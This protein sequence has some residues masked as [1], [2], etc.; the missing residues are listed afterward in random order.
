MDETRDKSKDANYFLDYAKRFFVTLKI[1]M[2]QEKE[3]ALGFVD[4]LDP[5]IDLLTDSLKES[6]YSYSIETILLLGSS[7]GEAFR[8]IFNGQWSFSEKQGRWII[9]IQ[10]KDGSSME[11][12]VFRKIENRIINGMEDSI[13]YY[14]QSTK[15]LL[16]KGFPN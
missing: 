7:L 5:T 11:M 8:L 14:Y 10:T 3:S 15:S 4:S 13:L 1:P 6:G 9:A 2:F 16:E 12:N